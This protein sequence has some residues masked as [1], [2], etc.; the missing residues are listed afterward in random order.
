[1]VSVRSLSPVQFGSGFRQNDY[2]VVCE[3]EGSFKK[4]MDALVHFVPY[5]LKS[6]DSTDSFVVYTLPES[7]GSRKVW[8]V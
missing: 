4:V 1:M 3:E 2:P 5:T 7:K 6:H 8:V